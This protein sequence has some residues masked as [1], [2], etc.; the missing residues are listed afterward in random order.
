MQDPYNYIDNGSNYHVKIVNT[1]YDNDIIKV[2]YETYGVIDEYN[3]SVFNERWLRVDLP[4]SDLAEPFDFEWGGDVPLGSAFYSQV[5][6]EKPLYLYVYSNLDNDEVCS[7]DYYPV[8]RL[9]FPDFTTDIYFRSMDKT[10]PNIHINWP[11]A[12][13]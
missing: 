11:G 10:E 13:Q 8:G 4:L 6:A 12:D 2:V 7:T 3:D 5:N 1:N 9:A